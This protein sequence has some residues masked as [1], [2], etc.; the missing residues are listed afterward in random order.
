MKALLFNGSPR[1][2]NTEAALEAVKKG[3]ANV[4]GLEITQI[5]ANDAGVSPC[6]A[7]ESC[8]S[9]EGCVFDDDTNEIVNAAVGADII[10]FATPVYWWG[11][12]AQLKVIIDKMYSQSTKLHELKKK[13]GVIVIGEAE[14]DDMQY[15]IIPQQFKCICDYLGWDLKFS[16]TYTAAGTGDL[17]ADAE[18]M[19]ELEELWKAVV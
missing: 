12:T 4:E 3:F 18:A 1:H 6:I 15:K 7:C 19:A 5:N 2:G 9:G 16:K 11:I 10:V 8:K 13:I 14:Q 17:A